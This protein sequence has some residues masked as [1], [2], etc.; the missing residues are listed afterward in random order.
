MQCQS[1]VVGFPENIIE[2]SRVGRVNVG[3]IVYSVVGGHTVVGVSNVAVIA[4]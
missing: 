2:Y 3:E 1:R 4:I